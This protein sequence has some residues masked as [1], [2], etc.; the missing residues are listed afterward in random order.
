VLKRHLPNLVTEKLVYVNPQLNSVLELSESPMLSQADKDVY[1]INGVLP[2]TRTTYEGTWM[3]INAAFKNVVRCVRSCDVPLAIKGIVPAHP[4]LQRS[5][6]FMPMKAN[7]KIMARLSNP[8]NVQRQ[9]EDPAEPCM[10]VMEPIDLVLEFE[11][12]AR[13]PD[14][15]VAIARIKTAFLIKFATA[16]KDEFDLECQVNLSFLDVVM[17]GYCFRFRIYHAREVMLVKEDVIEREEDTPRV[18]LLPGIDY[19]GMERLLLLRPF[20]ASLIHGFAGRF[21]VYS[22]AVRLTLRWCGAHFFLRVLPVELI[23]LLVCFIFCDPAPYQTPVSGMLGLR[24]FFRLITTFP[25][26]SEPVVV[27][28]EGG[29]QLTTYNTI[30]TKHSDLLKDETREARAIHLATARYP[31]GLVTWTEHPELGAE[32]KRMKAYALSAERHLASMT[33]G[34]YQAIFDKSAK[35][36]QK[37]FKTIFKTPTSIFDGY[38]ELNPTA[39]GAARWY[40]ALFPA[41]A[42][43]A[44]QARL[45]SKR[46]AEGRPG[47]EQKR[48]GKKFKAPLGR[49]EPSSDEEELSAGGEQDGGDQDRR[50]RVPVVGLDLVARFVRDLDTTFGGLAT[51]HYDPYVG[52]KVMFKWRAGLFDP[53]PFAVSRTACALP[54]RNQ[55]QP[56]PDARDAWLLVP[57]VSEIVQGFKTTGKQVVK[58]VVLL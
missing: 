52:T 38:I 51:F 24:R 9:L 1:M 5:A 31:D 19:L 10:H 27:D 4:A 37:Q 2:P 43:S 53:Q 30:R 46:A 26:E 14:D 49:E 15:L 44:A 35:H 58:N 55:A 6:V 40:R 54:V 16:L 56:K 50:G 22:D 21:P 33:Q 57:N 18:P 48:K 41:S 12:S 7:T 3:A 47:G 20:H 32:L 36:I 13:W 34:G 42:S 17:D 11:G 29:M 25:F 23:E 28:V 39:M 8:D 45:G